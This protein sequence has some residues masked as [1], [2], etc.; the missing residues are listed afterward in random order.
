ML[1][2]IIIRVLCE[3]IST[4]IGLL[5]RTCYAM[6][7]TVVGYATVRYAMSGTDIGYA[8]TRLLLDNGADVHFRSGP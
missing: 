3:T 4:A 1:R 6:S 5:L 8:A 7:G 2:G